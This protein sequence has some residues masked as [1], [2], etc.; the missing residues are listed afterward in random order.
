[1][2][3]AEQLQKVELFKDITL[4]DLEALVKRMRP[5]NYRKEAVLFKLNSF[6]DTMYIILKGRVSISILNAEGQE[7]VLRSYGENEIF[8]E[9]SP[10]D[11]KARSATAPAEEALEAL[12]LTRDDLIAFIEDRPQV[13]LAMMRSL[14][15]RI[16]FTTNYLE[17]QAQFA[18]PTKR[19]V[20]LPGLGKAAFEGAQGA[21]FDKID[22]AL[23]A[24]VN[25]EEKNE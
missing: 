11:Q 6:G 8:G 7:V 21:L 22:K 23:D 17:Q 10:L 20:M 14:S 2:N 13:G 16:R 1:M 24:L 19:D 18:L 4:P 3:V 9:L 12:V 5:E 25:D 15:Q